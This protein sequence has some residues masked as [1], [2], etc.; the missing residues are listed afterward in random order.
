MG[1]N[2]AIQDKK[3]VVLSLVVVDTVN[4]SFVCQGKRREVN[5]VF[6]L[7]VVSRDPTSILALTPA[8]K[9]SLA[10]TPMSKNQC[11]KQHA[12]SFHKLSW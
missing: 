1:R 10:Y 11:M 2:C 8:Q 6:I 4:T 9:L 5:A 12:R 7:C 3:L